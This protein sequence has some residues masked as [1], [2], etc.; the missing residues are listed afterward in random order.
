MDNGSNVI[1][2]LHDTT[3]YKMVNNY[4]QS[5]TINRLNTFICQLQK[6]LKRNEYLYLTDF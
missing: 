5:K 6:G 1:S 4:H 3:Y 2:C